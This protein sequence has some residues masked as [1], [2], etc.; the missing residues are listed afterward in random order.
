MDTLSNLHPS[1]LSILLAEDNLVNQKVALRVLSHLGYHADIAANGLEVIKAI[2]SKSYDLIFMDIQMPIMDGYEATRQIRLDEQKKVNAGERGDHFLSPFPTKIIALTAY[3]FE[4]DHTASLQTGCDDYIAKPFTEAVL[5]EII[6]RH[7]DV[8]YC[9]SDQAALESATAKRKPLM[10]Q[11]LS[12]MSLAWHSQ[13]HEASLDL[14]DAQIRHLI[15]QIPPQEQTL[16]EGMN[17]L[18]D[19][20]NLDAIAT[21]TQP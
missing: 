11:D 6:S 15:A 16:I 20:F 5:F 12:M 3:A 14:N 7:L 21:L 19:N 8:Q 17:F 1:G 18:V 13:V 10:T 9:Y 4:D 2:S